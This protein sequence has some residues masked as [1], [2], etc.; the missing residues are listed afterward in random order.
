MSE[1]IEKYIKKELL[2]IAFY[3]KSSAF[4]INF[5]PK[6]RKTLE[7]LPVE[8]TGPS[9]VK[10]EKGGLKPSPKF[11]GETQLDWQDAPT[12]KVAECQGK[13]QDKEVKLIIR[14]SSSRNVFK[15]FYSN[16]E[17]SVDN[18]EDLVVLFMDLQ[19]GKSSVP[20]L[21][22]KSYDILNRKKTEIN[23]YSKKYYLEQASNSVWE[24]K[25]DKDYSRIYITFSV[26]ITDKEQKKSVDSALLEQDK[27]RL[28][29]V[30]SYIKKILKNEEIDVSQLSFTHRLIS[31]QNKSG[32]KIT[33]K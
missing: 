16:E 33:I 5:P 21:K 13:F 26:A 30:G 31:D 6:M 27:F 20:E 15:I 22:E 9:Q 10:D 7:S 29:S 4:F 32:F 17:F 19:E 23:N 2:K 14:R 8:W 25:V 11:D 1:I 28:N 3:L 18:L 12:W 24:V